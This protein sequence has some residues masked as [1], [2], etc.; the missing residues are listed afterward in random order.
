MFTAGEWIGRIAFF[1]FLALNVYAVAAFG[2]TREH[3]IRVFE[4]LV[5]VIFSL[6]LLGHFLGRRSFRISLWMVAIVSGILLFGWSVTVLGWI[7]DA[8][9]ESPPREWALLIPGWLRDNWASW[10]AQASLQAMTRTSALLGCMLMAA[11]FWADER[12]GKALIWTITISASGVVLFFFLQ[13]VVGAPFI[14]Y[15]HNF[16]RTTRGDIPVSLAFA[17]YRYHGNA[18][19]YLNMAWPIIAGVAVFAML[20]QT[21]AWPLWFAPFV[22]VFIAAFLNVSKLG[23][24]LA[25]FGVGLFVALLIPFIAKEIKR[26][27]RPIAPSRIAAALIPVVMLAVALPFAMPWKRWEEYFQVGRGDASRL[28]A[29]REFIKMI[30]DAGV[31]GI[32]PGSFATYVYNYLEDTPL[33]NVGYNMAHQDYLQTLIEWG[34]VGTLLWTLLF[35]PPCWFLFRSTRKA[36]DKPSR[37]FEGYRISVSDHLKAAWNSIPSPSTGVIA[38]GALTSILL[39]AIHSLLDMPMQITSL[40]FYFLNLVALGWT[41]GYSRHASE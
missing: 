29:Y 15:S 35:V 21:K 11:D 25:V 34:I 20:R 36:P 22:A 17:T 2:L 40:Q 23:G 1:S 33:E 30:P 14:L 26:S 3:D 12:R 19:D 10:D 38:A 27:R 8:A 5:A 41:H 37:E 7:S 13:K 28:P 18:V 24:V 4:L 6:W 31:A 9:L 32:G 39:V 16:M